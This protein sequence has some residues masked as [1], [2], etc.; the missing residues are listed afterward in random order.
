MSNLLL[1]E[2]PLI[3]L[4]SLAEKIGLN[5]SIIIQQLHYWLKSNGKQKGEHKWIFNTYEDWQKQFP[6]W[7]IS[8]IRRTITKLE[9]AN[10]IIVDNFNKLAID[11]TKWY[12]I[13]Y[14]L[15][16][17]MNRPSVQNEQS[18]CSE[19]TV[20]LSKMNRPLPESS[21]ESSLIPIV[22]I[23]NYLNHAAHKNFKSTTKSTKQSIN[24]R[25]R[26]GFRLIDF[27]KVVDNKVSEW[28]N[29]KEMDKYLRPDTLFGTKFE[30]YLNQKTESTADKK[31]PDVPTNFNYDIDAGEDD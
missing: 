6:F 3:I 25:W 28:L 12:R 18:T 29:D 22:E 15:L 7:S 23:I 10:F 1:D 11:K 8:T 4:P 21:S 19:W 9:K 24:A 31:G 27:K 17:S 20:G 30:S 26:E 2:R 16:E 5:E 14:E 13:N